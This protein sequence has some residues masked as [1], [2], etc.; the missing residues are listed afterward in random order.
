[1]DRWSSARGPHAP[2]SLCSLTA[3]EGRVPPFSGRVWGRLRSTSSDLLLG[4]SGV[5]ACATHTATMAKFAIFSTA[6][7]LYLGF[8]VIVFVYSSC[9]PG[10]VYFCITLILLKFLLV[11]CYI[12]HFLYCECALK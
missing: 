5:G 9:F 11:K 2:G 3:R 10:T 7:D 12:D 4:A 8:S 1:V 6:S